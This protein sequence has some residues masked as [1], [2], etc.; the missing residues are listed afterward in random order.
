MA[1]FLLAN[2][3][4]RQDGRTIDYIKI[5]GKIEVAIM[6]PGGVAVQFRRFGLDVARAILQCV[7][8]IFA[9]RTTSAK[10]Q[11]KAFR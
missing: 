11:I 8:S 3:K 2:C 6:D 10:C 5:G 7:E 4:Q 9:F 1:R